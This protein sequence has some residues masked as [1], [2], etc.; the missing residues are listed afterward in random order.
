MNEAVRSNMLAVGLALAVNGCDI[1][2][3][4]CFEKG[5]ERLV[6]LLMVNG[7][8]MQPKTV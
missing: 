4:G 3:L 2:E 8:M 7:Y 1:K 5:A 6:Y